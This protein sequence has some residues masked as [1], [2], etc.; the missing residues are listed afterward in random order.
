[1]AK[2][3]PEINGLR[4]VVDDTPL[5][6]KQARYC[7]PKCMRDSWRPPTGNPEGRP[8]VMT[9]ELIKKLEEAFAFGASDLEACFYADISKQTL[10]TYQE[11]HP[12]FT[13]RKER[14]KER[15]VLLARQTVI[16]SIQKGDGDLG[17][18]YLERKRRNEFSLKM[19]IVSDGEKI[20]F[21]NSVPRPEETK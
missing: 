4:C 1:M 16:A 12:E 17:L 5:R 15:P 11:R 20:N 8:T 9:P 2:A 18:K 19:D 10:Y 21:G 13:D 7:S 14:L 3:K 6:G